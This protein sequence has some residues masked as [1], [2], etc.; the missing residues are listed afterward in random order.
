MEDLEGH[1]QARCFTPA[2]LGRISLRTTSTRTLSTSTRSNS[3]AKSHAGEALKA[4]RSRRKA[5]SP[6]I[7]AVLSWGGGG[8]VGGVGRWGVWRWGW[9]CWKR[10]Y[11]YS[12]KGR[13]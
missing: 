2:S 4:Q 5:A 1:G 11:H 10:I 12:L 6:E 3:P 8:G 9:Q 7:E 13:F